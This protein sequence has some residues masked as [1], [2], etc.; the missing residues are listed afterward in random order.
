MKLELFE[1]IITTLKSQS[2][3]SLELFKLGIDLSDYDE[4]NSAI[5]TLLLKVYYSEAGED[6]ISWFVYEADNVSK[7]N[8]QAWDNNN[9]AICFDIPSLW[10]H[11]EEIRCSTD[12]E[13]YNIVTPKFDVDELL[14]Q[15]Y[16]FKNDNNK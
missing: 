10:K 4:G 11:V 3:K 9:V 7:D 14:E 5:I 12:F 8:I 2:D 1:K 6:W 16:N 13:E 15:L